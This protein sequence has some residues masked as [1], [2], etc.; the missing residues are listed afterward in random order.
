MRRASHLPCQITDPICQITRLPDHDHICQITIPSAR[1]RSH[2]PCQIVSAAVEEWG[3]HFVCGLLRGLFATCHT[4]ASTSWPGW[5][6][7]DGLYWVIRYLT[8]LATIHD[9]NFLFE[10]TVCTEAR[11]DSPADQLPLSAVH[12]HCLECTARTW[13]PPSPST[14]APPS[15]PLRPLVSAAQASP[16]R[17]HRYARR[18]LAASRSPMRLRA[19]K[20]R[21]RPGR[22]SS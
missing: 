22:T 15:P 1:S 3:D 12:D 20:R 17:F 10:R 5:P 18:R 4:T 13:Q 16:A 6:M 14:L 19:S 7:Q 2:L 9:S 11:R 21:W 8:K